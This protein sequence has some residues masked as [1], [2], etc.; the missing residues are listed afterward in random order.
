[1]AILGEFCL[2]SLEHLHHLFAFL[3]IRL[4]PF[5]QTL[6]L[7][8]KELLSAKQIMSLIMVTRTVPYF[9]LR[10]CVLRIC[11]LAYNA[12]VFVWIGHICE[13]LELLLL[14]LGLFFIAN[15]LD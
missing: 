5:Q 13:I 7:S 15:L 1:M 12:F 10:A 6:H 11:L 3:L 2:I 8:L 14:V 4:S 9:A